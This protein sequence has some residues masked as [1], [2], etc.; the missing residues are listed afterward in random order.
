DPGAGLSRPASPESRAGRAGRDRQRT[1]HSAWRGRD[2][3]SRSSR[4]TIEF[5]ACPAGRAGPTPRF[6]CFH[7]SRQSIRSLLMKPGTSLA[8][9]IVR[10]L[11]TVLPCLVLAS[12]AAAQPD[13]G[14]GQDIPP[15]KRPLSG[16]AA[17]QVEK[18]E[19]RIAQLQR[20]GRFAEAIGPA[21]EVAAIR[22][23]LQGADHWQAVDARRAV[24]DLRKIAALP[25]D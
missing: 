24:D 2:Q 14:P 7:F 15:W 21:G 9:P 5:R 17:S 3:V 12:N 16:E 22:T 4:S 11:I 8:R 23:R 19:Q 13:R 20:E 18:L 6:A 25:E 10:A 1:S